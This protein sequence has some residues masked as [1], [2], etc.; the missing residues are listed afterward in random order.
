MQAT[1][2]FGIPRSVLRIRAWAWGLAIQGLR[3][4]VRGS[5]G[6]D[7][8]KSHSLQDF[9]L[10]RFRNNAVHLAKP[11]AHSVDEAPP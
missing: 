2:R 5:E 7:I 11:V 8:I 6:F 9:G 10:R 1:L 3:C 4:G